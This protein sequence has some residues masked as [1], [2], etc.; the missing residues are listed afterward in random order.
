VWFRSFLIQLN[1]EYQITAEESLDILSRRFGRSCLFA[2]TSAV[3]A[4][5]CRSVFGFVTEAFARLASAPR[6]V[7]LAIPS[8]P[9][10]SWN[11]GAGAG[12]AAIGEKKF[13]PTWVSIAPPK[14]NGK[15]VRAVTNVVVEGLVA[16]I[17]TGRAEAASVGGVSVDEGGKAPRQAKSRGLLFSRGIVAVRYTDDTVGVSHALAKVPF[18]Y[19][20]TIV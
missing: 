1:F 13:E 10:S 5:R 11:S 20:K 7:D 8:S 14:S 6:N 3:D 19:V 16:S 15:Y 17:P 2:E 18:L 4:E 9:P 12:G